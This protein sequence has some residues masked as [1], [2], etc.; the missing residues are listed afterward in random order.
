VL[1]LERGGRALQTLLASDDGRLK[2]AASALAEHVRAGR[3]K[4]VALEKVDG[5]PVVGSAWEERLVEVGF[6]PGP[7]KLSLSA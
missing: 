7:R 3:L 6:S 5:E 4:R 2:L 1:Y